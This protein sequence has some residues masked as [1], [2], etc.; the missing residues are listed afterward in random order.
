[1]GPA[2]DRRRHHRRRHPAGGGA[3]RPAALL[4]EQRDFAWGTSSRSS[5]LVHG[6]LRYLKDGHLHLTRESVR[7]RESLLRDAPGWSSRRASPSPTTTGKRGRRSF[8]AGLAIYDLLA[9][10]R[11]RHW[12]GSEEFLMRGAERGAANAGLA[13]GIVY[14]DAKTDDARLVLRVLGEAMDHGAPRSTTW[15]RA[16]CCAMA[17]GWLGAVLHDACRWRHARGARAR[18]VDATGA[19]S[20][21]CMAKA[22]ACARCAAA[23]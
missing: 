13:G 10:R 12:L 17:A 18:G 23:T 21:A 19:W 8:L 11:E 5:K 9:G 16:R 6:G 14:T 4:V 15:R 3:A 20:G 22:R 2:G 1:V 7:E